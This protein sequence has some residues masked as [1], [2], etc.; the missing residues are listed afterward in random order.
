MTKT[1]KIEYIGMIE[2]EANNEIEALDKFDIIPNE[3]LGK[4]VHHSEVLDDE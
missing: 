2:V 1:Y 3:D 4:F